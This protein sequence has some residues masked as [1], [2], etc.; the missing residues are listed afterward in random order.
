[1]LIKIYVRFY[2]VSQI[3]LTLY[4]S[5]KYKWISDE[6]LSCRDEKEYSGSVDYTSNDLDSYNVNYQTGYSDIKN[7]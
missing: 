7:V 1:M 3:F 5:A 6:I 4:E 2:Y